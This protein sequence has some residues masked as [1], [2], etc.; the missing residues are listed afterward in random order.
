VAEHPIP[1]VVAVAELLVLALLVAP[2][3]AA[4]VTLGGVH[5]GAP[6]F[7]L[8]PFAGLSVGA[9][10]CPAPWSFAVRGHRSSV[11]LLLAFIRAY[12]LT[13]G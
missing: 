12:H 9:V 8:H 10:S 3:N 1:L 2:R 7:E 11:R 6:P 5:L 4:R 13:T